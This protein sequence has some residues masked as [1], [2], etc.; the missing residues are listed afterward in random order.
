MSAIPV[1]DAAAGVQ[2][3]PF[4]LGRQPILDR[5]GNTVA[6]ELL[7][8]SP[9]GEPFPGDQLATARVVTQAFSELGLEAVLG[10]C[11]GYINF[12]AESLYSELPEALPPGRIMLEIL[13]SVEITPELVQRCSSLRRQGFRFALDDVTRLDDSHEEILPLVDVIKVD[14]HE[15]PTEKL[16]DIVRAVQR[17]GM[18]L[19]A[20]KVDTPDRAAQ[21]KR[22]GFDL[23]QGFFFARP[24]LLEGRAADPSRQNLIRLLQQILGDNEIADIEE[25]VK[26]LPELGYKLIRL[27]NSAGMGLRHRV[28]SL[29][30]ALVILGRRRLQRWLQVMLFAQDG[31]ADFPSPLLTLAAARGRLMELMSE[32]LSA[33]PAHADRAF[34][35]GILSLLD[36]LIGAPLADI[37]A[38]LPLQ[39]DVREALLWRSGDLGLLLSLTEALERDEPGVVERLVGQCD[40][41]DMVV[42]AR[43]QVD[44]LSWA[45]DV[46][47]AD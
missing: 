5:S 9:G 3:T 20:E 25:T 41:L 28:D 44:A 19:L 35:T 2:A 12:D 13:E 43:L 40:G 21:C 46:G 30:H 42:L 16:G 26:H 36:T 37:L 11:R 38:P 6:Y 47:R 4:V 34:M 39:E 10:T 31:N 27:V 18:Q 45:A 1:A 17:P 15:V 14:V 29:S 32:R 8:R 22:L 23:F 33:D 7:F 24:V